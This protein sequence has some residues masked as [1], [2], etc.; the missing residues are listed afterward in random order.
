MATTKTLTRS[1][2]TPS[3]GDITQKWFVIDAEDQVL[4]RVAVKIAGLLIGKGKTNYTAN[5]NMADH[6]IVLN[7]KKVAV[8]GR[9]EAKEY[10]HHSGFPGG[11]K[12]TS[13]SKL[14]STYPDRIIYAAVRGML[15]KNRLQNERLKRMHIFVDAK[16]PYEHLNPEEVKHG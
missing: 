4:G 16:H 5:L 13:L 6:V 10:F 3:A 15:P 2:K 8:T 1:T 9:K 14:R 11:L 12:E 7:A